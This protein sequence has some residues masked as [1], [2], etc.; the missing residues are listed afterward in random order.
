MQSCLAVTLIDFILVYAC[1]KDPKPVFNQAY[2]MHRP[3]TIETIKNEAAYAYVI[4][5]FYGVSDTSVVDRLHAFGNEVAGYLSVG[6]AEKWRDD[7]DA[8][9]PFVADKAWESWPDEYFVS[10]LDTNVTH[11]M[12][13]RIDTLADRG[14]DWIE[15][16]NMDWLAPGNGNRQA[17]D[18]QST[19][20]DS[21]KYVND[22]CAYAHTKGI[23]CMAK[24]R[25]EDFET[26]DGITY[27]SFPDALNWWD[28]NKTFAFLR[29]GKPVVI[30]HYDES[31]CDG[32]YRYYKA[33]YGTD[34]IDFICESQ[35]SGAYLHYN[36]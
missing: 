33:F 19:Y 2:A 30:V 28:T 24:N 34:D 27:E 23:R 29:D 18:L 21:V 3:D 10:L 12:Q 16:D 8:L 1:T 25:I 31:D 20:E 9:R 15:F 26:F 13:K 7:F 35:E 22:L 4:M 6:T 17:Y 5:D 11:I 36:L 14:V 32:V